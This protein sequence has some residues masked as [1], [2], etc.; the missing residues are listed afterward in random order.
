MAPRLFFFVSLLIII[1]AC[2]LTSASA[3]K[4]PNISSILIF[5]D[6]TVDTGNNNY[7]PTLFKGDHLPYGQNFPGHVPTGRFSNGKLIPDFLA[8]YLGIKETVP[9][10]LDPNLSDSELRTG[11]S[12]ASAGSGY[13]DL[14][15]VTTAAIPV[16]RQ[17]DLFR[18]YKARLISVVGEKEAMKT[19]RK[20]L[21]VISAGTNDFGFNYYLL[22][23]RG[24]QFDVKGYQDF[25]QTQIEDLVKTLYN[26]GVRRIAIAGLPPMGCLPLLITVR[27]KPLFDRTCLVDENRDA[28]AYNQ[29]LVRL[30]PR[31]EKSLPGSKIAYADVYTTMMDMMQHPRKYGFTTTSRGCCGSGILE[32]SYLCTPFTRACENPSEFMFWDSIHPSEA[33]YKALAQDLEK[34][35]TETLQ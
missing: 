34:K 29:K 8:S 27:L 24:L 19:L 7:I 16:A 15:T 1:N 4:F 32:A 3:A 11:V 14:T 30:I 18:N 22:P 26:E 20:S 28:R 5:G 6:S 25:L 31:L 23:V 13:D 21:V 17:I 9:P 2:N 10:F 12:F 35:L 33:A